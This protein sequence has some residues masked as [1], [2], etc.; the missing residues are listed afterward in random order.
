ME[1]GRE[2]VVMMMTS[3]YRPFVLPPGLSVTALL[4]T[5]AVSSPLWAQQAPISGAGEP[6]AA[7][8]PRSE[9]PVEPVPQVQLPHLI[10]K[11]PAELPAGV[12]PPT[13]SPRAALLIVVEADGSVGEVE[14]KNPQGAPFDDEALRAV[15]RWKFEPA[16]RGDRALASRILVEVD[17][18]A[19]L[20][21]APEVEPSTSPDS[22][23]EPIVEEDHVDHDHSHTDAHLVIT[24][25]GERPL[26]TERRAASD[27][28]LHREIIAA[29]P[30][31]GGVDALASVPGLIAGRGEGAAVA[32]S[33]SLRGFHAEHGQDIEFKVGGLP[34]NL[35]SH[36][37]G[38]GYADLNFLIGELVD[39]VNVTEGLSDPAQ[40]DFAVAGSVDI[41]LGV[42]DEHRGLT[43]SS[44]YGSFGTW[45]EALVWAPKEAER[46]SVGAVQF[47]RT[48]GYGD[49]R[50]AQ[51]G[52]ALLQHS[53]GH[54]ALRFRAIGLAHTAGGER[55]G[56]VRKSD[57]D[58]GDL[59]Y[60]CTYGDA[61]A[62]NQ[63]ATNQRVM[64]GLFADYRGKEHASGSF[65]FW[66]GQD[67]FSSWVNLTGYAGGF[68][69]AQGDRVS[70]LS[71]Q[72][73]RTE[74]LGLIGR[75]RTEALDVGPHIHGTIEVGSDARL[76]AISQEKKLIDAVDENA[77]WSQGVDARGTQMQ[78][79]MW[80]DADVQL[81][82]RL[83]ARAGVRATMMSYELGD[84][85]GEGRF[86]RE[87][88][89]FYD[90]AQDLFVGP[91]ASLEYRVS[92]RLK[93]STSYGHGY[94]SPN[95]RLLED[96][97]QAEFSVVRS[98][99]LGLVYRP[100]ERVL[101]TGAG[102]LAYVGSDLVFEPHAG[103]LVETGATRRAGV[104]LQ[105][106]LRPVSGLLASF[107]LTYVDA[108]VLGHEEEKAHQHESEEEHAAHGHGGEPGD[109]LQG[110]APLTM[111][112][113]ANYRES[114]KKWGAHE[115][116]AVWGL[117]FTYRSP[118][119]LGEDQWGTSWALLDASAGLNWGPVD[120]SLSVFNLL[121]H[122]Y[123][124]EEY[125]SASLWDLSDAA[126]S[127]DHHVSV[128]P[129]LSLMAK[130][131]LTL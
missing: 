25:H 94:R 126:P 112:L 115:L 53:F 32:H 15:R 68:R 100:D 7:S 128:G 3:A 83:D 1:L 17:F 36:I 60:G 24:V 70:D 14:L 99:D 67:R 27:F 76:D 119:P 102:Y 105:A 49:N 88:E 37:H 82:K 8:S 79:S 87:D 28:F 116:V 12:L 108:R 107:S 61:S 30:H 75:Y 2:P 121:N 124:T 6:Q 59:C 48:Q 74:S 111:R 65:G 55:P 19:Q 40:G 26:R 46:Q 114:I 22:K 38:Q 120:L 78:L 56:V 118:K 64:A 85:L 10:E 98:G 127:E 41:G 45:R 39:E 33:Y 73:N 69:N 11:Y 92:P 129:P 104:M 123:G 21:Q 101:V 90:T 95:I 131:A 109:R 130:L 58:A 66:L 89:R 110:I 91:R 18:V 16:R 122:E 72:R 97:E 93:F 77:A 62:L 81:G 84:E 4:C 103:G 80:G 63:R 113:D 96:D 13:E 23:G 50:K 106:V 31:Q 42:D 44:S 51:L 52:S 29:A 20:G 71:E 47:S 54:G 125:L 43:V 5:S 9:P 86:R 117:G 35:P 34:I 57:M